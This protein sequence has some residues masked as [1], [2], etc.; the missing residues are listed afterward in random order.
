M[1]KQSG[2]KSG[3]E[4]RE[5][6]LETVDVQTRVR[7]ASLSV[8]NLSDGQIA[9]ILCLTYEQMQAIRTSS[10]FKLKYAEEANASIDAQ[11]AR[12]EGWD[13]LEDEALVGLIGMLKY[14]KDPKFLLMAAA[15][16]NRAE[17]R[18]KKNDAE[19]KVIDASKNVTN[20]LIILNM[21]RN[22]VNSAGENRTLDITPRPSEIPLKQSDV[23]A[24]KLVDALLA[25]ARE[26][27]GISATDKQ[28]T[29]IE[30]MA[31]AAGI[32]FDEG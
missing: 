25:P 30:K 1:D 9:D 29:D 10:E 5:E 15:A 24:P 23:P 19:T 7:A 20:N 31:K 17:R 8:K 13:T 32:V 18:V 26:K 6:L 22:Y 2:Q 11:I 12:E 28:L 14:N 4:L 21:N 27:A 16:A 3:E